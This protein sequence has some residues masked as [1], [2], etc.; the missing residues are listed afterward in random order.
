MVKTDKVPVKAA[1][2]GI[3]STICAVLLLIASMPPFGLWPLSFLG[4]ALVVLAQYRLLPSG[5]HWIAPT[6][7]IGAYFTAIFM[8]NYGFGFPQLIMIYPIVFVAISFICFLTSRKARKIQE[9]QAYR[10]L[11]LQEAVIWVAIDFI[12][13]L[14]PMIATAGFIGYS[15]YKT[16]WLIQPVSVFGMFGLNFVIAFFGYSLGLLLIWLYDSINSADNNPITPKTVFGWVKISGALLFVWCLVSIVMYYI[17]EEK[18]TVR[19]G[20]IQPG[21]TKPEALYEMTREAADLGAKIVVWPEGACLTGSITAGATGK[22]VLGLAKELNIYLVVEHYTKEG[23]GRVINEAVIIDPTGA[24]ASSSGKDHPVTLLNEKSSSEP[25]PDPVATP[26]G[27]IGT[28]VCYDQLFTDTTRRIAGHG[29]EIVLAPANEWFELTELNPALA[30]FRAVENRVSIVKAETWTNSLF[31][32]PKGRITAM[33]M[34]FTRNTDMASIVVS[35]VE[36]GAGGTLQTSF[37]DWF[38]IVCLI[39]ML[40][41]PVI[42]SGVDKRDRKKSL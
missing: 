22:E 21:T 42:I 9:R 41:L 2:I 33:G 40:V 5:I 10:Y 27:R 20:A 13:S 28:I 7:F 3:F 26:Y 15:F 29:A 17:P 4:F 16:P 30:V 19:I 18:D 8:M 6:F 31:V 37:G 14:V 34:G 38:G 32:N 12:R 39:G 25:A 35:E 36:T 24:V 1:A 11:P 23:G